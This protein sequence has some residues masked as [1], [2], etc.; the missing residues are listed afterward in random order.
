MRFKLIHIIIF[1]FLPMLMFSQY[2][3]EPTEPIKQAYHAALSL[4]LEE[5]KNLVTQIKTDDPYNLLVLHIENYIDFFTLFISEEEEQFK[6]LSKKQKKRINTL[7]KHGDTSSPYHL[8]VQAEIELHWS[9]IKAKFNKLFRA[10]NDAL[11]A[12]HMLEENTRRFPNFVANK[13]SLSVIH[14]LSETLPGIVRKLFGVR[15]SIQ[16]GTQEIEELLHYCEDHDFLYENEVITI[17]TYILFYQN[18][19]K[20]KAWDFLKDSSLDHKTNPL[21]SFLKATFAQKQGENALSLKYL[22]ERPK[23]KEFARF[24]YLDFMEGR[25]LLFSLNV[26]ADKPIKRFIE[27]FKG[28]HYIKE[29]YQKLAWYELVINENIAGYKYYMELCRTRGYDLIDEDK[30]ALKEANQ[31]NISI[32]ITLLK[33]RLLYDGGYY[34]KGYNLLIRKAYEFNTDSPYSSEYFYRLG[35]FTQA[36][37][38]YHDAIKYYGQCLNLGKK[39]SQYFACNSSLQMALIFEDQNQPKKAKKYFRECLSMSPNEYKNSLH[40]KAKSG[41]NRLKS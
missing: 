27:N 28:R 25:A 9:L 17:Y 11:S 22:S 37:K 40:Q 5:S 16:Q 12:Y 20:S 15:G 13:K 41:L 29:A 24:D 1:V 23:S 19:K 32:N 3:Y 31:Q 26:D 33:A 7:K 39:S 18:N 34:Q 2:R 4:R 10:S 6:A 38:N 35:R 21:A 14:V 8:F 36:L 30:Q